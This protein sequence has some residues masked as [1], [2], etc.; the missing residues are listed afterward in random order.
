MQILILTVGT[1][2]DVQP[3]VALGKGLLQAG[4]DVTICTCARLRGTQTDP[5]NP[6]PISKADSSCQFLERASNRR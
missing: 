1:R 6:I 5:S 3:Y 4:H 2:G